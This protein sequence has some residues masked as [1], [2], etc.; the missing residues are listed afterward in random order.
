MANEP[1]VDI[2]LLK[3]E[4]LDEDETIVLTSTGLFGE[5]VD[6]F[7]LEDASVGNV[8]ATQT[9]TTNLAGDELAR[10]TVSPA[11]PSLN[12]DG[13]GAEPGD[14][15]GLFASQVTLFSENTLISN[16]CIGLLASQPVQFPTDVEVGKCGIDPETGETVYTGIT[17]GV[18]TVQFRRC[19]DPSVELG[20]TVALS[21]S[22]D[23]PVSYALDANE[24]SAVGVIANLQPDTTYWVMR[25]DRLSN[26]DRDSLNALERETYL[27]IHRFTRLQQAAPL[28]TFQGC[29]EILDWIDDEEAQAV[30]E[31]AEGEFGLPIDPILNVT[32]IGGFDT[33]GDIDRDSVAN[34]SDNCTNAANA[35]QIDEGTA[36]DTLV[37]ADAVRP[38]DIGRV[39]QCGDGQ[40]VEAA[41]LPGTVRLL[42]DLPECQ[43]AAG[44]D[45]D[46]DPLAAAR[47]SVAGGFRVTS[48]DLLLMS[49]ALD[50]N[51]DSVGPEAI[52][53]QRCQP[54]VVPP[55]P[56]QDF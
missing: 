34:V 51:V 43:R 38:D 56:P 12:V 27:G 42:E 24:P 4:D 40:K 15:A 39:C 16:L 21:D 29:Q 13:G 8:P 1:T 47:C 22:A 9:T 11:L 5:A 31:N 50:P 26:F 45:P 6:F 41:E 30:I 19:T 49:Q 52:L 3:V 25:G 23:P 35:D 17:R 54:A 55:P 7:L 37:D 18:D 33:S 10:I 53:E 46:M 32:Q 14:G 28:V 20:A 2:G 36:V 44:N 48:A